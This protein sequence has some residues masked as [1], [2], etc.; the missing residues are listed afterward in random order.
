MWIKLRFLLIVARCCR[1][2]IF[3]LSN[4][5]TVR[6][7]VCQ[8][9]PPIWLCK[10]AYSLL[11]S[12]ST[13]YKSGSCTLT[14]GCTCRPKSYTN[15]TCECCPNWFNNENIRVWNTNTPATQSK[16]NPNWETKE[17]V[18]FSKKLCRDEPKWTNQT[19]SWE[20]SGKW[21]SA[22]ES[23]TKWD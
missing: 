15:S 5:N 13:W 20:K 18:R 21:R 8:L 22:K 6:C 12:P 14:N 9:H 4:H 10:P 2:R 3:S 17:E 7:W 16:I 1:L 23:E 11:S 19:S